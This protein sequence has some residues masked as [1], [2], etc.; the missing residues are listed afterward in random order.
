MGIL[1]VIFRGLEGRATIYLLTNR[2]REL[3]EKRIITMDTHAH[4]EEIPDV[5]DALSEARAAGVAA[6]VAVG[7]DMASNLRAM[8]L[9][10]DYPGFVLPAVGAHPSN[11]H[12]EDVNS[13]LSWIKDH[14]PRCVALGEV[15]VDY[16]ARAPR[17]LQYSVF[18]RLLAVAY[19]AEKPVIVHSRYSHATT[20]QMVR[21]ARILRAVFHWYSGPSDVLERLLADGYCI[22]VTP[23]LAY[24]QA[25]RHAAATSPLEQ[26]LVETDSP[27]E[28]Q[29][30]VSRPVDV[31]MTVEL[32]AQLRGM[33]AEEV[34]RITLKNARRFFKIKEERD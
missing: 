7:M 33:E 8:Q 20:L 24:S 12:Q 23:A 27:V 9:A 1:P 13:C 19:E 32:L 4:L 34:A 15:G 2:E 29:G 26:I 17:V 28:Y 31:L 18:A 22:S 16:K 11:L 21:E 10:K 3:M 30:K 25:H 5:A 14:L 6:V